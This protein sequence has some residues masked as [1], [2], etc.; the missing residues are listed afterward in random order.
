MLDFDL[1]FR[2]TR[3]SAAPSHGEPRTPGVR[4]LLVVTAMVVV[5]ALGSVILGITPKELSSL[6]S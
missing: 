3:R 4:N 5:L 6:L 1:R 2:M